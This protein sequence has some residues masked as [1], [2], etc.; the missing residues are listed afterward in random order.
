MTVQ[1]EGVA[2]NRPLPAVDRL[3]RLLGVVPWV[4][5]RGGASVAEI[6]ARFDYPRSQLAMDLTQV[7]FFV[8]VHPFTPDTLIEVDIVDEIVDIRYAE[9]FSKPLQLSAEEAARLIAAGRTLLEIARGSGDEAA[10][11]ADESEGEDPGPL[12]RALS[13]LSLSI[14]DGAGDPAAGIDVCLGNAPTETLRSLRDALTR[15]RRVEIEYYS[16]G[17]DE[18]TSR[19]VDPARLISHDGSWYLIGWCHKAQAERVFRVDRIRSLRISDTP[20]EVE[21][22]RKARTTPEFGALDSNVALRLEADAAWAADYFPTMSRRD[23]PDGSV[24]AV[25]AVAGIAWLERLLLQLGPAA[26]VIESSGPAAEAMGPG[27]RAEA[28]ARV[29]ARYGR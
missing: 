13:K 3:A 1:A 16:L 11:Y 5:E 2:A 28:A 12:M 14:G 20:I 27:L 15:R 8:G 18:L 24:E 21:P 6:S 9:W 10:A 4:V 22:T 29:L 26:Q 17:R 7:L 23:L 25:F 19:A